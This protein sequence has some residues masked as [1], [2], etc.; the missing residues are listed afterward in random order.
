MS[1]QLYQY[2]T[3]N[4]ILSRDCDHLISKDSEKNTQITQSKALIT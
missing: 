4:E 1:K 3:E 2:K